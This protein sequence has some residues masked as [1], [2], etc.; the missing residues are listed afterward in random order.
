MSSKQ[1]IQK[2][3]F[4]L[5]QLESDIQKL[6]L[7]Y[8]Y[9]PCICIS[10]LRHLNLFKM[11][12][13][14]NYQS[15]LISLFNLLNIPIEWVLCIKPPSYSKISESKIPFD[16]YVYLIDNHVKLKVYKILLNHLKHT[17]QTKIHLK[18]VN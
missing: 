17:K 4:S 18:I 15:I 2:T 5:E 1:D 13:N 11:V 3:M 16:V 10:G 12:K 9:P 6:K 7:G 14:P 8:E